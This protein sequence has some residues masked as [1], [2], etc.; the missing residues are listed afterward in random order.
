MYKSLFKF[1]ILFTC[2]SANAQTYVCTPTNAKT[3]SVFQA[4]LFSLSI[5]PKCI[6]LVSLADK[7][8]NWDWKVT[9]TNSVGDVEGSKQFCDQP[10]AGL[11][12]FPAVWRM[13]SKKLFAFQTQ[14][15]TGPD[16]LSFDCQDNPAR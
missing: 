1:I 4:K 15:P 14:G 9:L 10:D 13:S 5:D 6:K 2:V 8:R 3:Q 7:S 16:V 12:G 11:I